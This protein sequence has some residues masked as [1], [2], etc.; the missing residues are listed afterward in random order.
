MTTINPTEAKTLYKILLGHDASTL[1][2]DCSDYS[3]LNLILDELRLMLM[4][5]RDQ[6]P[7][8]NGIKAV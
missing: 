4:E 5:I 3:K 7:K 2:P 1:S 8:D 6:E